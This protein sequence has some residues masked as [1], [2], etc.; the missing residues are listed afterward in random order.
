MLFNSFEFL[1]FLPL[2][3]VVFYLLPHKW[4]WAW[5]LGGSYYFYMV[6]EPTLVLLLLLSTAVDFYCGLKIPQVNKLRKKSYLLMSI[7]VNIGLLFSF[8]YL[9]FFTSSLNT[10]FNYFG[11]TSTQG[12]NVGSYVVNDIMLPIGISFYTF[13]TLSYTIDVYRGTVVPEKHLGRFAL[14]VSFFPQLVAGPIE[15]A[16]RLLPQFSKKII[17]HPQFIKKGLILIAWGFFLKVVVADR[18]GMYVDE[19]YTDPELYHGLPLLIGALFFALQLYY[20]FSAYTAIAIG[21]A[22]TMGYDLMHNFN[23]PLFAT[24]AASFWNRWHISFMSWLKDYLYKPMGGYIVRKP[25]LIRNVLIIFF[26]VGLYLIG[27][28]K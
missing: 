22:Q 10:V 2:M 26:I 23:R 24:S 20:D 11:L 18:L 14:F 13:Q 17:P 16:G 28:I 6:H 1:I 12:S 27:I 21:A 3:V 4:R 15:R 5:L 9:T 19:V 25:A 8:K 7:L